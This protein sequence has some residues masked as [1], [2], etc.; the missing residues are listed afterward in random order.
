MSASESRKAVLAAL[1]ANVGIAIAKFVAFLFTR[2]GSML[3]EAAHSLA[4]SGNQGLLLIGDSRARKRA[5]AG[6]PFGY[7]RESY[8][9]AFVVAVVLFTAGAGFA[10]REGLA[11]LGHHEEI[12]SPMIA[13]GVLLVG[14]VL[15]IFSFR[16][17]VRAAQKLRR[18]RDWWQFV[19]QNKTA[20]LTVVLL[21]D[22]AAL[23]GLVLALLG[24]GLAAITG[25]PIWDAYGTLA[26]AAL[27]AVIAVFLAIETKSLLIGESAAPEEESAIRT[28]LEETPGIDHVIH[29][30]TEHRGPSEL[31]VTAKVAVPSTLVAAAIAH[32][33]DEAEARIRAAVPTARYIFLEPDLPR[34]KRS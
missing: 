18:D 34:P 7:A 2:S 23:L 16:T 12:S 3:A 32:T 17:A 13:V 29:L 28:A 25:N 1:V 5:D 27:L 33:I 31:L 20:E 30:R 14:I 21:E 22:A 6:H 9:F 24:V 4:D 19:R 10:A 11:K 8:F 15:E 26:I